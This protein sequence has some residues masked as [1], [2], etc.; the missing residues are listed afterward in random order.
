MLSIASRLALVNVKLGNP[1]AAE[2]AAAHRASADRFAANALPIIESIRASG[3]SSYVG[4][5]EALNSR[6]Y[7]PLAVAGGARRRREI[8]RVGHAE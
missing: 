7:A 6:G 4:I 3:S 2:A 5:A 1:R 8:C